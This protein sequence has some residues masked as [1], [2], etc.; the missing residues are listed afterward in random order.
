[1]LQEYRASVVCSWR[2]ADRVGVII[3]GWTE[4]FKAN[5]IADGLLCYQEF[6]VVNENPPEK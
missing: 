3:S 1:M 4:R 6:I 5:P 2:S